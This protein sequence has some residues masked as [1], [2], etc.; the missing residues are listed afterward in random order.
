MQVQ[1]LKERATRDAT[2]GAL[3]NYAVHKH[4]ERADGLPI[5]QF[6]RRPEGQI[7]D[8]S[9]ASKNR[10]SMPLN[11]IKRMNRQQG[12]AGPEGSISGMES[13]RAT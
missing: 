1:Y 12:R 10:Q 11:S 4:T 8:M 3:Q 5:V 6:E 2:M 7:I 9:K 13:A